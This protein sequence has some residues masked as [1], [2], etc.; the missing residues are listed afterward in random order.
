MTI[1]HNTLGKAINH[2]SL[3][4][5]PLKSSQKLSDLTNSCLKQL[6][7]RRFHHDKF[8]SLTNKQ[9]TVAIKYFNAFD[10]EMIKSN[11]VSFCISS[12]SFFLS[13]FFKRYRPLR[14]TRHP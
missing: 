4:L 8:S 10:N 3:F 2:K 7:S 6:N 1:Q 5:T 14:T 12:F 9:T 13:I 11:C